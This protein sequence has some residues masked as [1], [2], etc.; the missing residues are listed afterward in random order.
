MRLAPATK[1]SGV[2][3]T[4]WESRR[5]GLSK[6]TLMPMRAAILRGKSAQAGQKISSRVFSRDL[7]SF[8]RKARIPVLG[9]LW[10]G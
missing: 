1:Q 10:P 6:Q 2:V 5:I 7:P 4:A 8:S 3:N 9:V